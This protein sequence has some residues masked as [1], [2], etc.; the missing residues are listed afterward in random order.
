ML[1]AEIFGVDVNVRHLAPAVIALSI[2]TTCVVHRAARLKPAAT[3]GLAILIAQLFAGMLLVLLRSKSAQPIHDAQSWIAHYIACFNTIIFWF[4]CPV[5]T[6]PAALL[7]TMI[8]NRKRSA[9][10]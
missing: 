1:E 2:V 10:R 6:A 7:T 3:A 5:F 4:L 9:E 8:L